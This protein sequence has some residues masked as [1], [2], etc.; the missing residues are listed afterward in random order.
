MPPKG[1][2]EFKALCPCPVRD[3]R[4]ADSL[5]HRLSSNGVYADGVSSCTRSRILRRE[6]HRFIS[7]PKAYSVGECDESRISGGELGKLGTPDPSRRQCIDCVQFGFQP[8]DVL[9]F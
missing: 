1:Q 7:I 6:A 9:A 8:S 4:D 5:E 2:S 3:L